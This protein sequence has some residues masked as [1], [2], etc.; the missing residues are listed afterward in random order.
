MSVGQNILIEKEILNV[1][2]H[3]VNK[4]AEGLKYETENNN[5]LKAAILKLCDTYK[6]ILAD[7]MLI[8]H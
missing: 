8:T 5:F 6:H 7:I 2:K 4:Q 3:N 1:A